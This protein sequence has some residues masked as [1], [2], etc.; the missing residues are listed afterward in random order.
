MSD[1]EACYSEPF[2]CCYLIQ[3]LATDLPVVYILCFKWVEGG[4]SFLDSQS[5]LQCSCKGTCLQNEINFIARKVVIK[6]VLVTETRI[7]PSEGADL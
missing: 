5:F 4:T 3:L 2:S 1:W 6:F 7:L